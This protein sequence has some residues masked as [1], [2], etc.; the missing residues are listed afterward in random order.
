MSKSKEEI[1]LRIRELEWRNVNQLLRN[2]CR[3][4][5]EWELGYAVVSAIME[6]SSVQIC[7]GNHQA[8]M[9]LRGIPVR[10]NMVDPDV[11]KLWREVQ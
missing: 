3:G 11:I 9:T 8:E 6:D 5:I 2:G 10:E 4:N 7:E 1:W